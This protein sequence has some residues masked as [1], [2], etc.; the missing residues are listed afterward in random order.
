MTDVNGMVDPDD[1]IGPEG[2]DGPQG[3]QGDQGE[4]GQRGRKGDGDKGDKGDRGDRGERGEEGHR[5]DPGQRGAPGVAGVIPATNESRTDANLM[6]DADCVITDASQM[7]E[8]RTL[9]SIEA[10]RGLHV[11]EAFRRNPDMPDADGPAKL[12]AVIE[13]VH[14][15]GKQVSLPVQRWDIRDGK[16]YR[17]AWWMINVSP[18]FTAGQV[19]GYVVHVE[20]R[21]MTALN[22]LELAA[23][24]KKIKSGRI[25]EY[26]RYGILLIGVIVSLILVVDLINRIQNQRVM[27]IL[28]SCLDQNHRH[29]GTEKVLRGVISAAEFKVTGPAR[30]AIAAQE[31]PTELLIDASTPFR[32]CQSVVWRETGVK[33]S[34]R[35]AE[36]PPV[37]V[38]LKAFQ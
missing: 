23:Q 34:N 5:G 29:D 31:A 7:F 17:P 11:L 9:T 1:R 28:S 22:N 32:N 24:S 18:L 8:Q 4:R 6:L 37:P 14:E 26:V 35:S 33:V 13:Q 20:D 2:P 25:G 36:L 16:V 27:S 10:I 12:Q 3:I 30:A 21:T 15:T 38:K 19:S